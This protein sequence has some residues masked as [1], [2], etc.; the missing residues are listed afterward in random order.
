MKISIITISLL[1]FASSMFA[2]ENADVYWIQFTDKANN[3][4][5]LS[6]PDQFLSQKS[7]DR[8]TNQ[9][10][11]IDY[12]DL[13]VSIFYLDSLSNMG[14]N[15][16]YTSKWLN[17]AA[18]QSADTELIDTIEN[19][20]FISEKFIIRE[21]IEYPKSAKATKE[22]ALN[23]GYSEN[24]I[25]MLN[26]HILHNQG[27]TGQNMLIAVLDSGFL[28]VPSLSSFQ[29]LLN[30]NRVIDTRDFVDGDNDVYAHHNHGRAV[31]SILAAREEDSL[32][33][34]APDANY[35]LLRTEDAA[36]EQLIEEYN[37]I[38]AAEYADSVG[39]DIISVSLG[40]TEYDNEIWS[41]SN[42]DLDGRTAPIS[43]AA[44][45]AASRGILVLTAAGN[46]G[47]DTNPKI[48]TP[49]D[50]DSILTIGATNNEGEYA[51]F[52]SIGYSADGRVKPDIVAQGEATWFQGGDGQ[53]ESGNG[54]SF[55]TPIASGLTACLWQANPQM[56]NMEILRAIQ[57]SSSQYENPDQYLGYG[58][59]DFASANLALKNINYTSFG[60][61][62]L[63]NLYPNPCSN[64]LQIEF[65]SVDTQ[66]LEISIVNMQGQ[67]VYKQ[68]HPVY[69]TSYNTL[70]INDVANLPKGMYIL[71]ILTQNMVHTK[72]FVKQ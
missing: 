6:Q 42:D 50:A 70:N 39:A 11:S 22:N 57:E 41:Y 43:I 54:T 24:Q 72:A 62:M 55:S 59:P 58:I 18:I 13:P 9:N 64:V 44:T 48:S 63:T 2:Q 20:E 61:E 12:K 53:F 67:I 30:E 28:G 36:S 45:I 66:K 34:S 46:S 25:S 68:A 49:A 17:G 14:I 23:Y 69:R 56:S 37:W 32:V 47:N 31:L 7:L 35:L 71:R 1:L 21:L 29:A 15:I 10:I 52:S 51:S 65:Y 60:D 27:Y 16:R 38:A 26:G 33:G 3:N 19:V 4:Y 8:R 5:E 40:Y